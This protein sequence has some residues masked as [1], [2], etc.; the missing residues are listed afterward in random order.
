[1][2]TY[3]K[4]NVFVEDLHNKVH[5]VFGPAASADTLRI[6]L[7]NQ[8]PTG[9]VHTVKSN[10]LTPT[11][12]SEITNQNGYAGPINLSVSGNR[13]AGT[14]YCYTPSGT[15]T[16]AATGAIGPFQYVVLYNDTPTNPPDP[17]IA[18]WDYGGTVNLASGESFTITMPT[19]GV[20]FST[21]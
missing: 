4:F 3:N 14:A 9:T 21:V 19:S 2:A 15:V 11:G 5:D 17:L 8:I 1:M 13:T 6:F 10:V 20:L 16:I 18:W 12:L 7:S